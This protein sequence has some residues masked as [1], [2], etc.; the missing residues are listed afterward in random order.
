MLLEIGL[1]LSL[2]AQSPAAS[3]APAIEAQ[4]LAL[5]RQVAAAMV[6]PGALGERMQARFRAFGNAG[7]RPTAN[8]RSS[9]LGGEA[10]FE[11]LRKTSRDPAF[12]ER[13]RIRLSILNE[14]GLEAAAAVEPIYREAVAKA[15]ARR[16][17]AAELRDV[18]AFAG[19]PSGRAF[20]G[21]IM[22]M[23]DQPEIMAAG[24][25]LMA[26]SMQRMVSALDR[27]KQATAHLPP[28]QPEA[29]ALKPKR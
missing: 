26:A 3:G 12:A 23:E 2:A 27:I 22:D 17:S 5:A 19:T 11:E 24:K 9:G 6:P 18:L 14:A 13:M 21:Q 1:A 10:F 16:L 4:E 7:M 28:F 8:P 25:E 15:L 20:A 29:G